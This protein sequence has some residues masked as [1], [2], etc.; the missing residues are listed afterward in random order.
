MPPTTAPETACPAGC[1]P[2]DS[3]AREAGYPV[4][5]PQAP[6]SERAAHLYACRQLSTYRIA[7]ITGVD[8]QRVTRLLHRAGVA[9]KPGGAR[10]RGRT[11]R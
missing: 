8:R 2:H 10:R 9:V 4:D 5:L 3:A 1:C 11:A 7:A 6:L